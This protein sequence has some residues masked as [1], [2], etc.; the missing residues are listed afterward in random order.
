MSLKIL[1]FIILIIG[2][3]FHNSNA[4]GSESD[5]SSIYNL[6]LS[7]TDLHYK[8]AY[9][10]LNKRYLVVKRDTFYY[11]N[12]GSTGWQKK[13][14]DLN[15]FD[16][17]VDFRQLVVL[18]TKTRLLLVLQSGGYVYEMVHDSIKKLDKC[19]NFRTQ[20]GSVKFLMNDTIISYGGYG[21]WNFEPFFTYFDSKSGE[22]EMWDIKSDDPLPIARSYQLGYYDQGSNDFY[23]IGGYTS[24]Y[25]AK[26]PLE[27]IILSDVWRINMTERKW[28]KLGNL[29]QY[30]ES[31]YELPAYSGY[32][33]F[34]YKNKAMFWSLGNRVLSFLDCPN[35]QSVS[36]FLPKETMFNFSMMQQP[37]INEEDD[38]ILYA[39][40]AWYPEIRIIPIKSILSGKQADFKIYSNDLPEVYIGLVLL[41]LLI[42]GFFGYRK[43]K[44]YFIE[45]H[46][47][48][49]YIA[50]STL[51]YRNTAI[52]LDPVEQKVLHELSSNFNYHSIVDLLGSIEFE[53]KSMDSIYKQRRKIFDS[54]NNKV[55]FATNGIELIKTRKNPSDKRMLDVKINE[56]IVRIHQ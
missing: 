13:S 51:K 5:R 43:Y 22:W 17:N 6:R 14:Y 2:L 40:L 46:K 12:K 35:N 30:S 3:L 56:E 37:A 39:T 47:I 21:F 54:I 34:I 8:L 10:Q 26:K 9:D 25:K 42:I 7:A 53:N 52:D 27:H 28:E 16:S 50:Q 44:R 29:K 49:F 45:R 20:Y 33:T 32:N 4:T 36:Y 1:A 23:M 18:P 24:K 38:E 15:Q 55:Q 41:V 48:D 11:L 19:S 31:W